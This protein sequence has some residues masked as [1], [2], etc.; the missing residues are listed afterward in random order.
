MLRYLVSRVLQAAGVLWAAFTVS[1]VVLYLIPGDPVAQAAS[2][3]GVPLDAA[4]VA[5][6]HARYGLDRPLWAQYLTALEHA[7]TLDLGRSLE[8]GQPV[9][10]AIAQVLPATL[11][12]AGSALVLGTLF[13][14]GL[15]VAAAYT[16][17][18]WLRGLLTA[19]PSAGSAAPT[20]WT[21]LLLLQLF[22]FRLRLVPAFGGHGVAGTILPAITLAIPV[23]SGIG[24]VLYSS[25]AQTWRQPFVAIAFAKGGSRW[26]VQLRHVLRPAAV[27]ALAVTGVWVGVVLSGSVVVETVFSRPGIGRL[28]QDAVEHHD[29]P[30]VL[31]VV[32]L[33]ASAFVLAGLAVDLL[34]PVVDPR[35]RRVVRRRA[36]RPV[37]AAATPIRP[38][39]PEQVAA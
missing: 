19:L 8:T 33:T 3:P 37:D 7:V 30:V 9:T 20:F 14:G 35:A 22:S 32:M 10:Q 12:L 24:Q 6:L 15:A 29:I 31:G 17:S 16:R 1:F 18:R 23:G 34:L 25:L 4:A 2:V 28:T 13:G 38:L 39:H 21:G 5:E 11:E 26:W 36:E 27:P